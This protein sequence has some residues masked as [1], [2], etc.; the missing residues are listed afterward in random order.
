MAPFNTLF[1]PVIAFL[2]RLASAILIMALAVILIPVGQRFVKRLTEPAR[3]KSALVWLSGAVYSVVAWVVASAAF[4]TALGFPQIGLALSGAISLLA[5]A[6]GTAAK[7]TVADVISGFLLNAD[8]DFKVGYIVRTGDVE[9]RIVEIDLRKT[10]MLNHN[11]K[12]HV[13]PNRQVEASEWVVLD[14]SGLL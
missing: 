3:N 12:V 2:P 14:R 4:F 8:H 11:G 6:I 5:L 10:R 13:I 9:G 1:E 7:D